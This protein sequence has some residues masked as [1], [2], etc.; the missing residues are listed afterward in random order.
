MRFSVQRQ[1]VSPQGKI[2]KR[3]TEKFEKLDV[4]FATPASNTCKRRAGIQIR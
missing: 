2:K 1:V 3:T 4:L